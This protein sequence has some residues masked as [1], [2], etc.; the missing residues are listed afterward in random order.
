MREALLTMHD[1]PDGARWLHEGRI[2]RFVTVT[3][4]DYDDIRAIC[5]RT[6]AVMKAERR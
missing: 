2:D 1:G 5:A 4:A 6:E 3:D